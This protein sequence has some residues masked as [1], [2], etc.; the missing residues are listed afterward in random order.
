MTGNREVIPEVV[1]RVI[2]N[3]EPVK[4]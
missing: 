1:V 4:T 2:T 3:K